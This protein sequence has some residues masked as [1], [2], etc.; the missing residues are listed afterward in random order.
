MQG[1]VWR[2]FMQ[3]IRTGGRKF[4]FNLRKTNAANEGWLA[5]FFTD[6]KS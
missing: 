4:G 2:F 6:A 5:D 1:C 3:K